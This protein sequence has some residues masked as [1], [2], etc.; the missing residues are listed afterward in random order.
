MSIN[1]RQIIKEKIL[2]K[3]KMVI[4]NIKHINIKD[5]NINYTII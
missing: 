1:N 2:L 5:M 3:N 4:K